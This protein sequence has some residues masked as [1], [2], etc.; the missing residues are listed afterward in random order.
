MREKH[1]HE[2]DIVV[3]DLYKEPNYR[4]YRLWHQLAKYL[5]ENHLSFEGMKTHPVVKRLQLEAGVHCE[6]EEQEIDLG[7]L[8]KHKVGVKRALSLNFFDTDE[9]QAQEIWEAMIDHVLATYFG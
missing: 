8:G 2:G 9:T 7:S 5:V 1:L 3:M 6:V 4:F